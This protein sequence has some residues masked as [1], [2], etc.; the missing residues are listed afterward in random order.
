MLNVVERGHGWVEVICGC[1]FSGK[2][3][4]LIRRLRRARIARQVA[5]VFKPAI[6]NR[7]DTE[8]VVSH[9]DQRIPSIPVKNARDIE[10]MVGNAQVIGIDEAQFIE[11]DLPTVVRRLANIGKRVV[12]AGL[13]TDYRGVPFEPIP[14]L[15]CEAEFVTKLTAVCHKC[16]APAHRTQRISGGSERVLVGGEAIYEARCRRC[17]EPPSDSG[18]PLGQRRLFNGVNGE[19]KKA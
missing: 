10:E 17:W 14:Q 7:Y 8:D 1:M 3:E 19:D 16:G 9:S 2:T 18:E 12:I 15:M 13:D 11:G 5:V 4:E 6:D